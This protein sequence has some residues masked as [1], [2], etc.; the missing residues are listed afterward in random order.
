MF[1]WP[2]VIWQC[3][4]H[5]HVHCNHLEFFNTQVYGNE[6]EALY[7]YRLVL[8]K[9]HIF[10]FM[11]RLLHFSN[12]YADSI[13][14][15]DV[16]TSYTFWSVHLKYY[17]WRCKHKV[18]TLSLHICKIPQTCKTGQQCTCDGDDIQQATHATR[19]E[20]AEL[21]IGCQQLRHIPGGARL[22]LAYRLMAV[23]VIFRLW[24]MG[25]NL[26]VWL[27]GG[28]DCLLANLGLQS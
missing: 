10:P 7:Q 25:T 24:V 13:I 22:H 28:H 9:W 16:L 11:F 12:Q 15:K 27:R 6:S 2:S 3:I 8:Y 26:V 19:A 4:K 1:R 23:K 18:T 21:F 14:S 20:V 5:L 17:I